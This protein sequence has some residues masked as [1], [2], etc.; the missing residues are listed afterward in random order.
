MDRVTWAAARLTR[1][2]LQV[3]AF[4]DLHKVRG[5]TDLRRAIIQAEKDHSLPRIVQQA[6]CASQPATLRLIIA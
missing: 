6:R 2:W 4:A 1:V 3:I 5:V